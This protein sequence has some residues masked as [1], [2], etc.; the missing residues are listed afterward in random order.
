MH[1]GDVFDLLKSK[2]GKFSK[3]RFGKPTVVQ[4]LSIP[5]VLEG[6]NLL[7][8]ANTGLGKTEACILPILD[9]LVSQPHKPISF[10]YITPLRSLNRN[11]LDRIL[12]W[13]NQLDLEVSV[14]HGDTTTYERSQQVE[15]TPDV[16]ISTP[17]TLQSMIVGSRMREHLANIRYLVIDEVHELVP[18]KRGVQLSVG[19]E[20]LKELISSSGH[21]KPQIIGLSATIGSPKEVAEFIGAEE[22]VD[23][24]KTREAKIFV[25]SPNPT[26]ADKKTGHSLNLLPETTA[27]LQLISNLIKDKESVIIFTNTRESAEVLS[28]RMKILGSSLETHHSSLSKDVR[29]DV[30]RGFKEKEIHAL[31]ATSSLELGI[32][33]GSIDFIVQY[34][35]PRQVTKLLQRLGR[36]GHSVSKKSDGVIVASDTDDCFESAAIAKLALE[37]K[38]EPTKIYTQ[39]LDVLAH[40]IIGLTLEY[41]EI[42]IKK[43]YEII[44]RAYPFR[45]L[46]EIEFLDVCDF[47]NR[48][49]LV[50]PSYE[51]AEFLKGLRNDEDENGKEKFDDETENENGKD[52]D[53]TE[54]DD[55]AKEPTE[56]IQPAKVFNLNDKIRRRKRSWEYY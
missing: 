12:W 44:K 49:W 6:K 41:Y 45:D 19:L 28:S 43:A 4:E 5:K 8:I 23:V 46:S 35:S 37:H 13:C 47:L 14:R 36:S 31:V 1:M 34:M 3:E 15:N 17:E 55:G 39:S 16:L 56:K 10:L 11:L 26:A 53:N 29:I 22:V 9:K 30:E 51:K 21:A 40:Q 20:R 50:W 38:I 2:V 42:E 24:A 52:D 18:S 33:I 48:L 7:I 25:E 27:R 54:N 32:D